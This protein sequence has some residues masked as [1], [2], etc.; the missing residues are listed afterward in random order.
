MGLLMQAAPATPPIVPGLSVASGG[1]Q[2]GNGLATDGSPFAAMLL[3]LAALAPPN[4]GGSQ[5]TQPGTAS[6]SPL[7]AASTRS[8]D[9][10]LPTGTELFSVVAA[11][12]HPLM[13]L[14]IAAPGK[15]VA[16]SSAA[17]AAETVV[18]L[19]DTPSAA[20]TAAFAQTAVLTQ[21]IA[22]ADL[23]HPEVP[24]GVSPLLAAATSEQVTALAAGKASTVNV[25]ADALLPALPEIHVDEFRLRGNRLSTPA[26]ASPAAPHVTEAG[27][28][29]PV[30][31]PTLGDAVAQSAAGLVASVNG[32][33][34]ETTPGPMLLRFRE[35]APP[36]P[37]AVPLPSRA[38]ELIA[39]GV[40]RFD[41]NAS[42][43]ANAAAPLTSLPVPPAETDIPGVVEVSF[44]ALAASEPAT[45]RRSADPAVAA[46]AK[47]R[48]ATLS[49]KVL[50]RVMPQKESSAPSFAQLPSAVIPA[51]VPTVSV[52]L[53]LA[54]T[55]DADSDVIDELVAAGPCAAFAVPEPAMK[56][57]HKQDDRAAVEPPADAR[58]AP[59]SARADPAPVEAPLPLGAPRAAATADAIDL[60]AALAGPAVQH[61][62]VERLA[63][64]VL[65]TIE[66]GGGEARIHLQPRELGDVIIHIRAHGDRVE[67]LVQAER[68]EAV[69]VIREHATDLSG[70]LGQRGLNLADLN[71]SL[72]MQQQNRGWEPTSLP[73]NRRR[74]NGEFASVLG[75]DEPAATATHNRLRATYNPDG[76][77]MYRV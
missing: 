60:P 56:P 40:V 16:I 75:I 18:V 70:L 54:L 77:H 6:E 55:V 72:G 34:T 25:S 10:A 58:P 19:A 76:A 41:G 22:P 32:A 74:S 64:A 20:G 36:G 31:H 5:S 57:Q 53:A 38:P 49:D 62:S 63:Q 8:T 12:L 17:A 39:S 67:V 46:S 27:R 11:F 9:A 1:A 7:D 14:V 71:V 51:A 24:A 66:K 4:P 43:P 30:L 2:G 33:A 28:H 69:N 15:P 35:P 65:N 68:Q 48:A 50:A 29:D 23:L 59:I 61:P 37:R 21:S 3:T 42:N 47:T 73:N 13:P 26:Q 52:S 45:L 44:Q